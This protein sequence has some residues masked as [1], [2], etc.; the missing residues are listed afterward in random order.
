MMEKGAPVSGHDRL[1]LQIDVD[2]SE[3]IEEE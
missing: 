2:G 3:H 1:K